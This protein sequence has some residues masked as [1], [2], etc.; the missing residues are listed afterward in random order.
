M[1]GCRE[2]W[3]GREG[4]KER[5][6]DTVMLEAREGRDMEERRKRRRRRSLLKRLR[7]GGGGGGVHWGKRIERNIK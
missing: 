2:R 7:Q 6:Y 3:G 5:E 1:Y 4:E